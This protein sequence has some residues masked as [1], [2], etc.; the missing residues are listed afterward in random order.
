[1]CDGDELL[2]QPIPEA[3]PLRY[4][5]RGI[6]CAG[7][8]MNPPPRSAM[9]GQSMGTFRHTQLSPRVARHG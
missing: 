1:M 9:K 5:K 8:D 6:T 3:K 7:R 4:R 2:E